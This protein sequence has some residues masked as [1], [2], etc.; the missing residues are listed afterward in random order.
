MLTNWKTI[1]GSIKRLRQIE[2]WKDCGGDNPTK[3]RG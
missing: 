1:T 3:R 2:E